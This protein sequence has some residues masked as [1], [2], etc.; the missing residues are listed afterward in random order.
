VG[1]IEKASNPMLCKKLDR[2][3]EIYETHI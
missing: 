3:G 1:E 2:L